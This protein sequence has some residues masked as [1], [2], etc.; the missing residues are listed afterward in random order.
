MQVEPEKCE[1]TRSQLCERLADKGL[2]LLGVIPNSPMLAS[3]GLDEVQS[4]TH[5][6]PLAGLDHV[7][8]INIDQV[9]VLRDDM[10][11]QTAA[12][13]LCGYSLQHG[14]F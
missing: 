12:H 13:L 5:A 7:H 6:T 1:E 2:P 9:C 4:L 11:T 3:I 8:D 14:Y 10:P